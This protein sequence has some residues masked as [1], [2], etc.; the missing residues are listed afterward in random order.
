MAL[1][2]DDY[3][4]VSLE[5]GH[6][7]DDAACQGLIGDVSRF[8]DGMADE[9]WPVNKK[10]HD[11]PETAYR[12]FVA[13]ETL[14]RF[15][16]SRP[17]WKVTPAAY[18][19]AT[20]WVAVFDS[21]K[22][23]PVVSFNAEMDAL[24]DIGHAC[25]HNL[26]ASA[27]V[28]GA[29]ATA[30][31]VAR[32]DLG[33]KVV[34]FGTPAE[35]GGGGKIKLLEAGAYKE[36]GVDLSLMAHPGKT[37]DS[38]LVHTSALT[39]YKVEYFGREAHA[40]ANPWLGINAL[41]A[42]VTAYNAVSVLRQQTMPGDVIQTCITNG[43]LRPNIIPAYT[44][45]EWVVRA[46][47]QARLDVL[48]EKAE[49]C[50]E[51][52]TT[53]TGATVKITQ[54]Q[55]YKDHMPNHVLG[56]SY[57]KHFNALSPPHLIPTDPAVD[58]IKGRTMASTDQGDVSHALPSLHPGFSIDAPGEANG[59]HNPQFAVSAGTRDAFDRCLRAAKALAGTAL[60]VLTVD[61]MLDRVREEWKR[62]VGG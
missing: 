20:A 16:A 24:K 37:P 43:G 41:D 1:I 14:T 21:G 3:V 54:R 53:A 62:E 55:S 22:K 38:A 33:G 26:I 35:E 57:T 48:K 8:I 5:D 56:A 6:T 59:P 10:I 52:G 12:E 28:A 49:A 15:M 4:L 17:G 31:V 25:G 45:A 61:G 30:E 58:E 44:S 42:M 50:F 36:H 40:A 60:D 46:N 34:I 51:A 29:L 18:G 9:L 13:H 2:E 19:M 11:T 27:S 47:T 23:G 7:G 32:R 39:F